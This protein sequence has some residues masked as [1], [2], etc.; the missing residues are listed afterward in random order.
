[1]PLQFLT[2][3]EF[4]TEKVLEEFKNPQNKIDS[5]QNQEIYQTIL[6]S[7]QSGDSS[8]IGTQEV[9]FLKMND[10]KDWVPYFFIVGNPK[11]IPSGKSFR[12]FLFTCWRNPLQFVI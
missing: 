12:N 11:N 7:F 4:D 1:M 9:L 5:D 3:K 8:L 6:R 2:E 10:V